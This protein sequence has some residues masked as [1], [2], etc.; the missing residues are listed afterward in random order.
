MMFNKAGYF[1]QLFFYLFS[2]VFNPNFMQLG[3]IFLF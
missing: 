3:N 2:S 1:D